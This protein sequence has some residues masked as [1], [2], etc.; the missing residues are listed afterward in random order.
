MKAAFGEATRIDD[1]ITMA[2]S[3]IGELEKEIASARQEVSDTIAQLR[4]L[5]SMANMT[6]E[7]KVNMISKIEG[8]AKNAASKLS[9]MKD[10]AA[11]AD[12][13]VKKVTKG[14]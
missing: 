14:K 1:T 12:A 6:T 7:Q 8:R 13:A 11:A 9:K 5:D 2:K 4:A 3:Q 10:K